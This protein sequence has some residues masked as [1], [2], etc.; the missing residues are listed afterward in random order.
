M[1]L[2]CVDGK[3]LVVCILR[4]GYVID[5][6]GLMSKY[7]K[8]FADEFQSRRARDLQEGLPIDQAPGV[9]KKDR[10]TKGQP[11][12]DRARRLQMFKDV[13]KV[14]KTLDI[15][16]HLRRK[17]DL[18]YEDHEDPVNYV[19]GVLPPGDEYQGLWCMG[20]VYGPFFHGAGL[21][22]SDEHR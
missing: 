8:T 4:L 13:A 22:A 12:K 6:A 17:F 9:A 16:Y 19:A 18:W 21:E 2:K 15:H 20:H 5:D 14:C 3:A 11:V 1:R 7:F 10:F